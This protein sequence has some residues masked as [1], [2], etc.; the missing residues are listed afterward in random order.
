M[1]YLQWIEHS[2]VEEENLIAA[3]AFT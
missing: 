1:A 3:A 2:V